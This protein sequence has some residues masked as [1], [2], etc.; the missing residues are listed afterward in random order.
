M[1][2]GLKHR[3]I[4]E[5]KAVTIP[6]LVDDIRIVGLNPLTRAM[7]YSVECDSPSPGWTLELAETRIPFV[8]FGLSGILTR[9][10]KRRLFTTPSSID[11]L[12]DSLEKDGRFS[13]ELGHVWISN[14]LFVEPPKRGHVYR[15][16]L[17]L[18]SD[19]LLFA[20]QRISLESYTARMRNYERTLLLSKVES[21]AFSLWQKQH[22]AH[23]QK[24]YPKNHEL[25]LEYRV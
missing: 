18:F 14:L 11:R 5:K 13:I 8:L 4:G 12:F 17:E 3:Y 7:Y 9:P 15:V 19:C 1:D 21:L 24:T 23:A 20:E 2:H 22:I 10:A 16:P 6:V 25:V